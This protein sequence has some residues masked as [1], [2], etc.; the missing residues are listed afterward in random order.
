[1]YT[2]EQLEAIR[3]LNEAARKNLGSGSIANATIGFHSLPHADRFGALAAIIRFS[4]FGGD[5]DPYGE[6]DF[7][8]VYRLASSSW[9]DDRPSDDGQIT[10]AVL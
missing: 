5:N 10:T 7:G 1:M 3:R 9:T 8:A 6:R 4:R 2:R